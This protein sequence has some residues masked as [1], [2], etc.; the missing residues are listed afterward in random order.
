MSRKAKPLQK[1]CRINSLLRTNKETKTTDFINK[2][3]KN[4]VYWSNKLA[5]LAGLIDG[6]GY[7]KVEKWG[8]I[9]LVVGMCS[10]KT[11]YWIHNNFGGNV[12][13]QKT[14]KGRNFYVWRMNSGKDLFWLLLL[15][16]PF[17]QLK[18]TRLVKG[19]ELLMKRLEKYDFYIGRL[20]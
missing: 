8:T 15:L 16:I 9:R 7:L 6:E 13:T 3:H 1:Y 11:I 19:F 4:K 10:R 2:Y 18:K 5:Y 20:R 12:T 14:A 17:L